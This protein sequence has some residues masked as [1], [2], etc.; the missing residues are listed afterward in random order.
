MPRA[1]P[2]RAS[3]ALAA[4]LLA[5]LAL[6]LGA[7]A[8][9]APAALPGAPAATPFEPLPAGLMAVGFARLD[10]A[11][12]S[13]AAFAATPAAGPNGTVIATVFRDGAWDFLNESRF[14]LAASQLLQ[15]DVQLELQAFYPALAEGERRNA[16]VAKAREEQDQSRV[17][18]EGVL[19]RVKAL[20]GGWR[21]THGL[22]HATFAASLAVIADTL[23]RGAANQS[24]QLAQAPAAEERIVRIAM[25]LSVGPQT[26][27]RLA[28]DVLDLAVRVDAAGGPPLPAEAG[29]TLRQAL[30]DRMRGDSEVSSTT[31]PLSADGLGILEE[32]AQGNSTALHLAR[33][34]AFQTAR[35]TDALEFQ[36]G[37]GA[38]SDAGFAGN[39]RRL[40]DNASL[41]PIYDGRLGTRAAPL[42]LLGAVRAAGYQGLHMTDARNHALYRLQWDLAPEGH[43]TFQ[44]ASAAWTQATGARYGSEMFLEAA[45]PRPGADASGDWLLY[46]GVAVGAALV[47]VAIA[48][49][50]KP[51]A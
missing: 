20:D 23:L 2:P 48:V 31:G 21:T 33:F 43:A 7:L 6:P 26:Y 17:A 40:T 8:A 1:P 10:A 27:A 5:P 18:V 4:L 28:N 46:G 42:G 45:S 15:V 19:A 29:A 37:R 13:I 9:D 30:R 49:L 51:A 50:R 39:L 36:R 14:G 44:G 24:Q 41:V 34:M 16:S 12:R 47:V 22:E 3:L 38:L 25:L 35:S 11:N 32:A